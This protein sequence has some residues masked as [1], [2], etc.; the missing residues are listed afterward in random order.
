MPSNRRDF[1]RFFGTG[2]AIVPV[3]SGLPSMEHKALI[4]EP[5]TVTIPEPTIYGP[6]EN[7]F[8]LLANNEMCSVV[9]FIKSGDGQVTRIDGNAFISEYRCAGEI[10]VFGSMFSERIP[11]QTE[12]KLRMIGECKSNR[13]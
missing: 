5:P 1:L 2:A 7:L 8:R 11:M 12:I 6:D 13:V 10:G 9:A 3:L 4:V